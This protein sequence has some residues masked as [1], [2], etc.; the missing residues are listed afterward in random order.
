MKPMLK[1]YNVNGRLR[2]DL[3]SNSLE[4]DLYSSLNKAFEGNSWIL[5]ISK[6]ISVGN[7]VCDISIGL[8][9][10]DLESSSKTANFF[11]S[12]SNFF[13]RIYLCVRIM[14]ELKVP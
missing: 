4:Q 14:Q 1:S 7:Y 3:C 2:L 6:L 13:S 9:D 10:I 5:F 8:I 11:L 12:L